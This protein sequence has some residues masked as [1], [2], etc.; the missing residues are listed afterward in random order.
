[1]KLRMLTN[2]T[3]G[4]QNVA[5]RTF[6]ASAN[7]CQV[8]SEKPK[9]VA[10][11]LQALPQPTL[12]HEHIYTQQHVELRDTYNKLIQ[13]HIEPYVNEWEQVMKNEA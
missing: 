11:K 5:C 1:M 12:E 6:A 9:P 8:V 4:L 7:R 13:K 10:T 3:F 2:S